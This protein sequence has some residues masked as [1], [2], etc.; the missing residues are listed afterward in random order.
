MDT[1]E[2]QGLRYRCLEDCGYCCTFT[3]EVS[4]PE[5]AKLRT[6]LPQ[7]P[8]VR[9]GEML[10]LPF[11]GACGACTLLKDR[12]C[13]VYEDRPAHCRYFP[14]HVYFGRRTEAYVN[15]CCRGVEVAPGGH[16]EVEFKA[17]VLDRATPQRLAKDQARADSV[18]RMFERAARESGM[19]GDVDREVAALLR[20]GPSW[21]RPATWPATPLEVQDEA[22]SPGEAWQM[23]LAPF[24]VPDPV[25]RPFHLT[26]EL[27]WLGFEGAA[28][29]I[30][31][32]TLTEDG[33]LAPLRPLGTFPDWPTLPNEVQGGLFDIMRRLAGRDLLA[34]SIYYMVDDTGY[35][36]SIA[37]AASIR[38]G[39]IAADLAIRADI[40]HRM[41]TP[42]P[43][44]PAEVDR[45]YDSAF[46]DTPT[47]GGWL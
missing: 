7:L 17:Q 13:T 4:G 41:G 25:A 29:G 10:L 11:Q 2:L 38:L 23:A 18:H 36:V 35:E 32:Q 30:Q 19:W 37:D 22:G 47:I 39:D 40:L 21:F 14:F 44:V 46:L 16:L 26:A 24:S 9:A 3:P 1:R 5:L 28:E 45:F 33:R 27:Q 31:T 34:G 8:V 43:L 12:R 20:R 6:R 15:R 42:W